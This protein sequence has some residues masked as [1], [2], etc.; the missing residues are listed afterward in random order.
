[1]E[2]KA[3]IL[4]FGCQMN[5][6]DSELLESILSADGYLLTNKPD[7]ANLIVVN[8]CSVR[9]KAE[10]RAM[11][12]ITE[13]AT[14]KKNNPSLKLLV[15]GCMAKRAGQAIIDS[16]PKVDYVIGPDFIPEILEILK[17]DGNQKIF[18]E[19][20]RDNEKARPQYLA[21][22]TTAFLAISRGCDNYCSYC[23]VP[24]VRGSFRSRVARNIIE[25]VRALTEIGV[26]E[27]TLL[28]QNVNSYQDDDI[29][30]PDL[31]HLLKPVMPPRL[32]FLTSH[33]KDLSDEIIAC[34]AEIS[35]LCQGLH[36]PLQSGSD[37]ILSKMNR[38]YTF[39]HYLSIINKLRQAVPDVSITTDLIVGF[40]S[41][42]EEDFQQTLEA[43]KQIRFDSAF[44]FRYSVRP[45]TAAAQL[46]DDVSDNI[47]IERLNSLILIQQQITEEQNR[48][49]ID[50]S[51]E[52]LITGKSRRPPI[53]PKGTARGGQSVLITDKGDLNIGDLISG[54][55]ISTQAKTLF[56]SFEKFV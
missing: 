23:I 28:G 30:F 52:I 6:Y 8:T 55:V 39:E 35:N 48:R 7:E 43:V 14:L 42:S 5:E 20:I 1:M 32:R 54:R 47:K 24:Y 15:A 18:V 50:K 53:I 27:I 36:L 34:F 9:Q 11:A 38:G 25:Q 22:G 26:K 16:I 45:G 56:A 44:M 19:E 41:E 29:A 37:N 12:R 51:L 2:K 10:D 21:K 46:D 40:P 4:T 33:P 17:S 49:W 13:I 31:L 3:F